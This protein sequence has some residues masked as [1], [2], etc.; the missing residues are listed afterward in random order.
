MQ[1]RTAVKNRVR[2]LL[3]CWAAG[4]PGTKHNHSDLSTTKGGR[5]LQGLACAGAAAS[6]WTVRCGQSNTFDEES[7]GLSF[8]SWLGG[9]VLRLQ[10]DRIPSAPA[11]QPGACRQR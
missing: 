6:A 8:P 2:G 1:L 4:L 5:L 10:L 11:S 7:V 9:L 3:G